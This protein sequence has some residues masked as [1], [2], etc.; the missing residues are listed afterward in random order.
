MMNT[1]ISAGVE[2]WRQRFKEDAVA[3]LDAALVGRMSLGQYDRARPADAL[4]QMLSPTDILIADKA[5]Q[6]WLEQ[7]LAKPMPDDLSPKRYAD[8]LVEAFRTIH[9]LPLP[10]THNWCMERPAELRAWLRNFT[11]DSSRDPEAALLIMLAHGQKNRS[12]LFTWMAVIRRGRP[13]EHVRHALLGLRKMPADDNGAIESKFPRAL[14]RGLLD[15]GEILVKEGD[16]K[17][18]PWLEEVDFLAAVYPMSQEKWGQRFREVLQARDVSKDVQ[19]WLDTRFRV[20]VNKQDKTTAKDFIQPPHGKNDLEPL[21]LRMQ[22]DFAGTRPA[23]IALFD[24]Y[25]RYTQDSGDSFYLV[26]S[27]CNAGEQLLKHDPQWARDLAHEAAR[28]E[29]SNPHTWTLLARSLEAEGDWRRAEA[30]YWNARRRF[31][32]NALCYTQLGHA[33]LL[34]GQADLGEM[35]FRQATLLFPDN[36]ITW[37]ELG[38]S[39]RV[40]GHYEQAVKMYKEAQK[41]GFNRHPSIAN[42]LADTLLDLNA[43]NTTNNLI[44]EIKNALQWAEQIMPD[45]DRNQKTLAKIQR[46]FS[47]AKNGT[48][49]PPR[50]LLPPKEITGGSL[51]NLADITGTDLSHAVPLGKARLLRWQGAEGLTKAR[52]EL[53]SLHDGSAKLIEEGLI[54]SAEQGW[55]ATFAYF[56]NCWENYAGDGALRVHRL[57]AQHR[58]GETVDWS[59][60]KHQYPDLFPVIYTEENNR[61]P[62]YEFKLKES[63][64]S[65]EQKQQRWFSDLAANDNLRDW[66]QEDF[67][68]ARQVA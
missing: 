14:L 17:G 52:I 8:A 49:T 48:P 58:A 65:E 25:R 67:L 34:H 57:R 37:S 50:Q 44:D 54:V 6:T 1:T 26:R 30:V 20:T 5:M 29:P 18:K 12:L 47:Q 33:L 10:D 46:R 21:L 35:V 23:L 42:A 36:P 45:D 28:W 60:E 41:M 13:I 2:R 39:L 53:K 22:K 32:H 31:P 56:D 64:L 63:E 15:Y 4:T 59:Q 43:L 66:A 9:L 11:L 51:H 68:S 55:Q 3:A 24:K 27:F 7:R 38:H 40:T 62:H 16:K 61:P 19:N